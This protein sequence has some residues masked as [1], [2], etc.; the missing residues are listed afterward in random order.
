M[1]ERWWIELTRRGLLWW[2]AAVLVAVAGAA[3]LVRAAGDLAVREAALGRRIDVLVAR[4]DLPLGHRVGPA[5]LGRRVV[6]G[7]PVEPAALTQRRRALGRVVRVPLLAGSVV[8]AR[9]LAAPGRQGPAGL[10]AGDERALRIEVP[11]APSLRPGDV[12][13]VFVT[14]D[15]SARAR[16]VLA[17]AAVLAVDSRRGAGTAGPGVTLRVRADETGR[18]VGAIGAGVPVVVVA[19]AAAARP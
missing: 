6:R 15:G 7:G 5:D 19:P 18:V 8:T 13:D 14:G 11:G 10:L 3:V 1:F 9:H 16:L 17:G 2:S 4:R 12:V